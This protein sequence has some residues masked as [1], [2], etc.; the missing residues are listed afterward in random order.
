V[1]TLEKDRLLGCMF[2]NNKDRLSF[3]AALAALAPKL[4]GLG[5]LLVMVFLP[6]VWDWLGSLVKAINS[7][8]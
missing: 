1:I 5:S 6:D 2:T 8:R 7:I 4:L 3:G